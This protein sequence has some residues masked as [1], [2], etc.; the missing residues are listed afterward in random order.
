MRENSCLFRFHRTYGPGLLRQLYDPSMSTGPLHKNL[1]AQALLADAHWDRF[2][3][4][5]AGNVREL[6]ES[7][8]P[9]NERNVSSTRLGAHPRWLRA[10]EKPCPKIRKTPA[11][12]S[13]AVLVANRLCRPGSEHA[14][15]QW[16]E[17]TTSTARRSTGNLG[18]K[19]AISSADA[20]ETG[21][22]L[23][24]NSTAACAWVAYPT[25]PVTSPFRRRSRR[26]GFA[27]GLR[28]CRSRRLAWSRRNRAL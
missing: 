7:F 3:S 18:F 8:P 26:G 15:A 19:G 28:R 13:R 2:G 21:F 24:G 17:T 12:R 6:R 23:T 9:Q 20:T 25:L 27:D 1:S 14:L 16:L 10:K 5:R 4:A 22:Y 11:G